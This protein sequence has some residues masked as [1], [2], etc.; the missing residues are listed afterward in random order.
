MKHEYQQISVQEVEV[1]DHPSSKEPVILPTS[2]PE[3]AIGC[4]VC[5]MPL[6]EARQKACPGR[7]ELKV[8]ENQS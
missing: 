7:V 2:E 5:G 4:Q 8:V 6:D 3:H 1:I